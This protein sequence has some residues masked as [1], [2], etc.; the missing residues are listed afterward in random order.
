MAPPQKSST[1]QMAV[2]TKVAPRSSCR[3]P[4]E[5]SCESPSMALDY[6]LGRRDLEDVGGRDGRRRDD[7][8][9]GQLG[10]QR[11]EL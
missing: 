2:K 3:R 6:E 5:T 9:P 11:V 8:Q 7:A 10:E 1:M 4:H